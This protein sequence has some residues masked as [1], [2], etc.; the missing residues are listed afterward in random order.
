MQSSFEKPG[1]NNKQQPNKFFPA[2]IFNSPKNTILNS[3]SQKSPSGIPKYTYE[4]IRQKL[5]EKQGIDRRIKKPNNN[6]KQILKPQISK[7]SINI[8][9]KKNMVETTNP[10][11]Q[12]LMEDIIG[13]ISS[14]SSENEPNNRDL[15]M[16]YNDNISTNFSLE[17]SSTH[18]PLENISKQNQ[19]IFES[20]SFLNRQKSIQAA[21][22]EHETQQEHTNHENQLSENIIVETET[23]PKN[24][25]ELSIRDLLA[26]TYE[27]NFQNTNSPESEY[28]SADESDLDNAASNK[29]KEPSPSIIKRENI[30]HI[31]ND[32][33]AKKIKTEP[34]S[35]HSHFTA[36][37]PDI[38]Q[39]EATLEQELSSLY[40][41]CLKHY[42]RIKSIPEFIQQF[43]K[44]KH[45]A[46]TN[47]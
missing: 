20:T 44:C 42:P 33:K 24:D 23:T 38:I 46:K 17:S 2:N 22:S 4:L 31:I 34:I 6:S 14:S 47:K 45:L 10:S 25:E 1:F 13:E 29:N 3:F 30:D 19:P 35:N 15:N 32:I 12:I 43:E 16:K 26:D 21:L 36:K 11:N 40:E 41:I 39:N 5:D 18:F 9:E 7:Q 27:N 8:Q 28:I 37:A